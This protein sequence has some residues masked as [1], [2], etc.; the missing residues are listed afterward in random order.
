MV[1]YVIILFSPDHGAGLHGSET[2]LLHIAGP[3]SVTAEQLFYHLNAVLKNV[4]TI[5]IPLILSSMELRG[6]LSVHG[7]LRRSAGFV[8]DPHRCQRLPV[9][10]PL[11]MIPTDS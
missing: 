9:F 4:S 10:Q 1:V 11:C 2:V 3:Y 7:S 6:G 5:L 8:A